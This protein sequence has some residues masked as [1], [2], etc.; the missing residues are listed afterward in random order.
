MDIRNLSICFR[1]AYSGEVE[2]SEDPISR[3]I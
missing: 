2:E 3:G 1:K